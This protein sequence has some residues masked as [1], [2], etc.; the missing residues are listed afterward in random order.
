MSKGRFVL[1]GILAGLAVFIWGM[2]SHVVFGIE[3]MA[4]KTLPNE[5][6][7]LDTLNDHVKEPGFYLYPG[8]IEEI[9]AAPEAQQDVLMRHYENLYKTRPHG[10]LILSPSSGTMY[11]FPMLLINELASNILGGLIAAWLLS[12]ALG[13]LRSFAAKVL[14]V[15]LLGFFAV[16]AIDFSY[17]NWY[18]F[19]SKYFISS[20][21]DNTLGWAFAGIVLAGMLKRMEFSIGWS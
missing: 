3:G 10:V 14:F 1:A 21:I 20:L 17:W 11:S 18:D 13:S 2:L 7:I 5:T 19:P 8:G 15:T 16:I 12:H 9:E 4:V 6:V